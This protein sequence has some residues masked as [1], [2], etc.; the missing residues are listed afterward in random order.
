MMV[1][2]KN[3]FFI[4]V[5]MFL[6]ALFLQAQ[7]QNNPPMRQ[8]IGS[9]GGS[10]V[11]PSGNNIDYTVGE[12]IITTVGPFNTKFLTQGFQQ[13]NSTSSTLNETVNTINSSCTGANNGSVMFQNISATGPV[14]ISF[15]GSS[16]GTTTLFSN[17]APGTYPYVISDGNFSITDTAVITEA[18]IDCGEQLEFYHGI[19]PNQDGHN[20][21]WEI[22]GIT[23][24]SESSVMIYN[25]W[26]DL[27]WKADNYDNKTI[28]WDGK[29]MSGA[30]LPD[31]TYFYLVEAGGKTYKG[32][33][34]LTH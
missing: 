9:S 18:A 30:E 29:N 22:D 19:T 32:W 8:V 13:P 17:L 34:E 33:V 7:V 5:L 4:S 28:V 1:N 21:V 16:P 25:R 26:G 10:A 24:F 6:H 2:C 11:L 20:D 12:S 3:K 15:N 23:N 31:A 14:T 27:V